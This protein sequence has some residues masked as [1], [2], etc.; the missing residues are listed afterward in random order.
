MKICF[1]KPWTGCFP[2]LL[3]HNDKGNHSICE[4][5]HFVVGLLLKGNNCITTQSRA[6]WARQFFVQTF[7]FYRIDCLKTEWIYGSIWIPVLIGNNHFKRIAKLGRTGLEFHPF[8]SGDVKGGA[9][10]FRLRFFTNF[11]RLFFTQIL[12]LVDCYRILAISLCKKY[13]SSF[14]VP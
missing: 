14:S 6:F 8:R 1:N 10:C 13:N 3:N 7:C 9:A 12:K 4:N 2:K 5:K 11:Q